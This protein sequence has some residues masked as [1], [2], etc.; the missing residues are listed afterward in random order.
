MKLL[1]EQDLADILGTNHEG[2]IVKMARAVRNEA[3]YGIVFA[4]RDSGEYVT[5]QFHIDNE[6]GVMFYWGHYAVNEEKALKD[7]EVRV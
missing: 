5:W 1:N 6:N 3:Y 7:F 2:Y 4:E